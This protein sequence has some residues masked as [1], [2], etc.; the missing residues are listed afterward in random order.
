LRGPGLGEPDVTVT[1]TSDL[2]R[3][4]PLALKDDVPFCL[5][6]GYM[7]AGAAQS[8]MGYLD[9]CKR[10]GRFRD[11]PL[12]AETDPFRTADWVLE[13]C[14]TDARG[15]LFHDLDAFFMKQLRAR[16][17]G[18]A[19]NAA[20]SVTGNPTRL[21]EGDCSD[22]DWAKVAEEA[23]EAEIRWDS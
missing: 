19:L 2:S 16:I 18:Q 3:Y 10:V 21:K 13:K 17:R 6:S 8:P 22:A 4:F 14:K 7:L 20:G 9:T 11:A 12:R 15:G 1:A 5:V 23:R